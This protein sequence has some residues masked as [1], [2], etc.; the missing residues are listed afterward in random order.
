[1]SPVAAR[2]AALAVVAGS[3][4]LLSACVSSIG[5][6]CDLQLTGISVRASVEDREGGGVLAMAAFE[7]GDMSGIGTALELCETDALDINGE[8]ARPNKTVAG[9]VSY[10]VSLPNAEDAYE[11]VFSREGQDDI[12]WTINQPEAFGVTAPMG[13]DQISRAA[14]YDVVWEPAGE[15]NVELQIYGEQKL[16]GQC[17]AN[18]Q[19]SVP[20]T[21]TYVILPGEVQVPAD[22]DPMASCPATLS[23]ERTNEHPYPEGFETGGTI[24]GHR[25]V[26]VEITSTP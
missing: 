1:M 2:I 8:A 11:F 15:G 6:A 23:I 22:G 17:L 16:E 10:E 7:A 25:K 19:A 26:W 5:S 24:S 20:D 21:G 14:Q 9:Q 18:A 12:T 13:G 3:L 4:P